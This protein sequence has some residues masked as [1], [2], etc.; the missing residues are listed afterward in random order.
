[1]RSGIIE[2]RAAS[3]DESKGAEEGVSCF[4]VERRKNRL[5]SVGRQR[6]QEL[7]PGATGGSKSDDVAARIVGVRP[8]SGEPG[9]L[10]RGER[11]CHIAAVESSQGAD[12]D[13]R[14]GS[15]AFGEDVEDPV[16]VSACIDLAELL[17]EDGVGT[18]MRLAQH[19]AGQFGEGHEEIHSLVGPTIWYVGSTNDNGDDMSA[20]LQQEIGQTERT[21]GAL[22]VE[23]VLDGGPFTSTTEWVVANTLASASRTPAEV[24]NAVAMRPEEFEIAFERMSNADLIA[25]DGSRVALSNAGRSAPQAARVKTSYVAARIDQTV[26]PADREVTIRVLT[27]VRDVTSRIRESGI[28]SD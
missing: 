18:L 8:A 15:G 13:L 11:H 22:L 12:G 20:S 3:D 17:S 10:Q 19:P 21:L 7:P 2:R 1:M 5:L 9:L 24:R 28:A 4:C 23:G 14:Q 16:V 25:T 27:A 26:A 6:C